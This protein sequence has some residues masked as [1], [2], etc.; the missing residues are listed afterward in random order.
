MET[1]TT[2]NR[3]LRKDFSGKRFGRLLVTGLSNKKTKKVMYNCVCD[4]GNKITIRQ[5]SLK[6]QTRSCGCI[7]KEQASELGKKTKLPNNAAHKKQLFSSY[8]YRAVM[9]NLKFSMSFSKFKTLLKSPCF[10][11]GEY[12]SNKLIK[13][14]TVMHYNGID[15]INSK[16]GYEDSNVVACCNFC[17]YAKNDWTKEEFFYKIKLIYAKIIDGEKNDR[18]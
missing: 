8:R 4:C 18:I 11:C 6:S 1:S 15:R 7:Q 17:N 3:K 12:F 5:D 10:Y 16:L 13:S 2:F 9:K 14:G